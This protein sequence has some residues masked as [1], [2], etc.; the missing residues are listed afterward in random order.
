MRIEEENGRKWKLYILT[1][2]SLNSQTH[3][4]AHPACEEFP[5]T[6]EPG[7]VHQSEKVRSPPC[8]SYNFILPEITRTVEAEVFAS[9]RRHV[10]A[11]L[12]LFAFLYLIYLEVTRAGPAASFSLLGSSREKLKERFFSGHGVSYTGTGG[13]LLRSER[14]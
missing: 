7:K 3:A 2:A 10:S 6:V 11:R 14:L 1:D 8:N 9:F 13:K 4:H 12:N 5:D